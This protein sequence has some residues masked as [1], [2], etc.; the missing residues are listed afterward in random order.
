MQ[1]PELEHPDPDLTVPGYKDHLNE[2][3]VRHTIVG[4]QCAA[5]IG[6]TKEQE[7]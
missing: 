2:A 3:M 4:I 1:A 7:P 5:D 6:I